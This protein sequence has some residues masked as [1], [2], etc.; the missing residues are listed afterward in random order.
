MTLTRANFLKLPLGIIIILVLI[1]MMKQT[2]L[3]VSFLDLSRI[4]IALNT[5]DS[6]EVTAS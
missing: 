4:R 6:V 3:P 1:G 2:E 5:Q